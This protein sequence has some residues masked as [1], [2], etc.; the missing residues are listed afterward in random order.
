[1]TATEQAL[2]V[3]IFSSG[4]CNTRGRGRRS[5]EN[6]ICF[7]LVVFFGRRGGTHL[8]VEVLAA[9]EDA[10]QREVDVVAQDDSDLIAVDA[11]VDRV[12]RCSMR[13]AAQ[14]RE[15]N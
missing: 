3:N 15:C 12:E 1:M 13:V 6:R 7:Q 8:D 11:D 5:K 10:E 4:R 9:E 14:R 2:T